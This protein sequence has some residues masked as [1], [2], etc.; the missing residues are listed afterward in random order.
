[1]LIKQYDVEDMSVCEKY[2]K[3]EECPCYTNK[4]NHPYVD[5]KKE[6]RKNIERKENRVWENH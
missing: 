1:M 2:I 5:D 3:C 6:F 4:C